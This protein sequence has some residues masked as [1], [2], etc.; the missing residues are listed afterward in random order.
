MIWYSLLDNKNLSFKE[1]MNM[2]VYEKPMAEIVSFETEA[3]MDNFEIGDL[4]D[5]SVGVEDW[6]E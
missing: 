3:V 5:I 2:K 6:G 4:P 1:D